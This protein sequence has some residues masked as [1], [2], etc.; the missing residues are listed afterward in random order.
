MKLAIIQSL[1]VLSAAIGVLGQVP[2]L[3]TPVKLVTCE[4]VK[5]RWSGGKAPYFVSVQ[6]GNNPSGPALE[7]LPEQSGHSLTWKVNFQAGT[8]LG[9]LLRDSNGATS[10]TASVTVQPGSSTDCIGKPVSVY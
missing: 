10:Q 4:P 6:D 3:N 9:F 2:T 1:V 7:Q 8:N 5:L